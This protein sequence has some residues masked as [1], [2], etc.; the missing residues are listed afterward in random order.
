MLLFLDSQV[1]IA[2][3]IRQNMAESVNSNLLDVDAAL[4]RVFGEDAA[5]RVIIA[6]EVHRA[7][8]KRAE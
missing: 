5:F 4:Q 7:H 1:P 3:P 6:V 2:T 8:A